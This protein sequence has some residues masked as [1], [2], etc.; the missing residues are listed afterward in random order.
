[1]GRSM[2]TKEDYR[3]GDEWEFVRRARKFRMSR[4]ENID[5]NSKVPPLKISWVSRD[6]RSYATSREESPR[7]ITGNSRSESKKKTKH[8]PSK[9]ACNVSGFS[10]LPG[11]SCIALIISLHDVC[12]A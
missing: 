4:K 10:C 3:S 11:I 2:M 6:P 9:P 5:V 12:K 8:K 1:M 7:F